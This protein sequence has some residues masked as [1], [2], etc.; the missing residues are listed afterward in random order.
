[1]PDSPAPDEDSSHGA[2]VGDAT[3]G[4]AP[5]EG[6]PTVE[7]T[8]KSHEPDEEPPQARPSGAGPPAGSV[9]SAGLRLL[10]LGLGFDLAAQIGPHP[11]TVISETAGTL[12][13]VLAQNAAALGQQITGESF[14]ANIAAAVAGQASAA[15]NAQAFREALVVP[16]LQ[17]NSQMRAVLDLVNQP[18]HPIGLPLPAL[19]G[20]LRADLH[21]QPVWA[22]ALS[23]LARPRQISEQLVALSNTLA[24][25]QTTVKRFKNLA[26]HG[27]VPDAVRAWDQE[28]RSRT[29]TRPVAPDLQTSAWN[30][31]VVRLAAD[32]VDGLTDLPGLGGS[33]DTRFESVQPPEALFQRAYQLAKGWATRWSLHLTPQ[34]LLQ[35]VSIA[36]TL[37][38]A[39]HAHRMTSASEERVLRAEQ[40]QT[41]AVVSVLKAQPGAF[42]E[43]LEEVPSSGRSTYGAEAVVTR[44]APLL[45]SPDSASVVVGGVHPNQVVELEQEAGSWARVVFYDHVAEMT[46]AG[47]V[48]GKDLQRL[49]PKAPRSTDGV[50]GD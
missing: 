36:L 4:A 43:A 21:V 31:L 24:S 35:I 18:Q 19:G 10:D 30:E 3:P 41:D 49:E 12:R 48:R 9:S 16:A 42:A 45:A 34:V 20:L 27:L 8:G 15:A 14:R 11:L 5:L 39:I 47:W 37:G 38:I 50:M 1:M 13:R 29:A 6:P 22:E 23:S 32:V 28:A 46:R 26:S 33:E 7:A 25:Y 40:D 44:E 17:W 2:Q